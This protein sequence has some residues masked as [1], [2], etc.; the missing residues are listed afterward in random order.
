[1]VVR[2]VAR[3]RLDAVPCRSDVYAAGGIWS[4]CDLLC[5]TRVMM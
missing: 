4:A 1:V 5:A 3:Y 2:D